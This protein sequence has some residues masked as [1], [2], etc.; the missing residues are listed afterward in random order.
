MEENLWMK[1]RWTK[2]NWTKSRSTPIPRHEFNSALSCHELAPNRFPLSSRNIGNVLGHSRSIFG[3]GRFWGTILLSTLP[4][5]PT[6]AVCHKFVTES[7]VRCESF[8]NHTQ[9]TF[10]LLSNKNLEFV[11]KSFVQRESFNNYT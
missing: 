8:N 2:M 9:Y 11:T 5:R 7:F 3:T 10:A 6:Q 1:R 4:R